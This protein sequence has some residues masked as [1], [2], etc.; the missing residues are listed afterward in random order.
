M[1]QHGKLCYR[2][3]AFTATI[4]HLTSWFIKL[5][6]FFQAEKINEAACRIAHE[7]ASEGNAIVCG[8]LSP[9][10]S[11]RQGDMPATRAEF[12]AQLA[13]FK[14]YKVDFVLAEVS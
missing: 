11:F 14:K 2:V 6:S 12:E 4:L 10:R 1:M 8:S 3:S 7:V 13:I 5:T 9:V